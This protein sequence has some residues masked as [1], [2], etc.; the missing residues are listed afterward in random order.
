M[1][2]NR[3]FLPLLFAPLLLLGFVPNSLIKSLFR[4]AEQ[5]TRLMLAE[6]TKTSQESAGK[7]PALVSPRTLDK[8]GALQLVPARDWTSGFFS[9][10][11]WYL[12]EYTGQREWADLARRYT[13]NLESEKMNAGTHDMGFKLYCSY[14]NGY[15]LTGNAND[16]AV[17]IQGARTLIKRFK[18]TAGIIRSWDH[19]KEVWQ[20]PVIIDNLMNLE[21]L[22]AATRLT[23]DSTFYKIAV[24]HAKTTMKNHYRPDNSSYHV[25]DYDTLTG[26]V[27]KKNTHQGYSDESAWAR[28]QAWGLY[29]YTMCYRE[30]KDPQFLK[31]AEAIAR[32]LLNHPHMPADLVPYYDFD[33]P[34]IPSEPRDVSA[35]A[36]MASALYELSTYVP[37][38]SYRAKADQV[39]TSL[40]TSYRSPMGQNHGF[41]LAHSTGSKISEIDVPLVYADY[42]FLEALLR[43]QKLNAKKPLF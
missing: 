5:Q 23:G 14:G 41:L 1:K 12:Y 15:R 22:F 36:I 35:A 8:A 27:I 10:E 6:V 4:D 42:Y 33:A 11:L 17:I 19:H 29:G 39:I 18:P 28:G 20:C 13:A 24:I 40:A 38:A 26:K 32:Y 30:T 9:G 25:V 31:Q 2:T 3:L 37:K 21:L 7:K 34:G 16:K 43:S